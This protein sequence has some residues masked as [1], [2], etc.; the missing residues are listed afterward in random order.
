MNPSGLDM[1]KDI[2]D[3]TLYMLD[4]STVDYSKYNWDFVSTHEYKSQLYFFEVIPIALTIIRLGN[5]TYRLTTQK[6]QITLPHGTRRSL[7]TKECWKWMRLMGLFFQIYLKRTI[8]DLID[9][10]IYENVIQQENDDKQ[11]L[12][13]FMIIMKITV[14]T[15]IKDHNMATE[16]F[17]QQR[18]KLAPS[19]SAFKIRQILNAGWLHPSGCFPVIG[20]RRNRN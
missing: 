5:T 8:I 10:S 17:I 1:I 19:T 2:R 20:R 12:N 13:N 7:G 4:N 9:S 6:N 14:T 3:R 18:D 15:I 11:I 16:D